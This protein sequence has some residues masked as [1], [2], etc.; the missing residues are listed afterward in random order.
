MSCCIQALYFRPSTFFLGGSAGV[1]KTGNSDIK[2]GGRGC[3]A[4]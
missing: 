3:G 2:D 1:G 4:L